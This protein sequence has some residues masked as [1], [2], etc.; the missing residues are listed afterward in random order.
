MPN[1]PNRNTQAIMLNSITFFIP[2]LPRKNGM[3]RIKSVSDIWETDIRIFGCFTPNVSWNSGV[4]L[5]W[6]INGTPHWLVICRAAPRNIA[7]TK[8]ITILGCLNRTKASRPSEAASDFFAASL[9]GGHAGTVNAY[10]P[11]TNEATAPTISCV[12]L[13]VQCI[14]STDHIAAMNPTVPQTLIGGTTFCVSKFL[15][16]RMMYE[17][18]L[19]NAIVG[20]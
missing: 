11:M 14:R 3:V 18:V 7:K 20:I 8:N 13:S 4:N 12:E 15:R 17:T 6:S 9:F 16:C 2:N 10:N 1:K 19:F 5:K